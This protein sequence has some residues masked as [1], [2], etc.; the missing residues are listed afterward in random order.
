MVPASQAPGNA[1]TFNAVAPQYN[2]SYGADPDQPLLPSGGF[3]NFYMPAQV[4][5]STS[6]WTTGLYGLEGVPDVFYFEPAFSPE[7]G[8]QNAGGCSWNLTYDSPP[9]WVYDGGSITGNH[10]KELSGPILRAGAAVGSV[11]QSA[12]QQVSGSGVPIY[13]FAAMARWDRHVYLS[14][15]FLIGAMYFAT[16]SCYSGDMEYGFAHYNYY[17]PPVNQFYFYAYSNCAAPSGMADSYGC[18]LTPNGARYGVG[19]C[20]AAVNLPALQLNSQGNEWY[21]W[22]AYI[23]QNASN[24]HYVFEAGLRDPYTSQP[25]WTC[26]G[27]PLGSPTFPVSTCPQIASADYACP[28]GQTFGSPFPI[29]QLYG[30]LGSVTVGITNIS[31]TPPAGRANPMLKMS[32][33]YMA[34]P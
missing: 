21:L 26:V 12:T 8:G 29:A 3:W 15:P 13:G 16:D 33:L 22:Y 28:T 25:V 32:Q 23:S 9:Y 27:D 24:G 4:T 7:S 31:N 6:G 14:A 30:A 2:F 17:S 18:M 1:V 11:Y 19:Q 5:S 34:A 20:G 10:Y